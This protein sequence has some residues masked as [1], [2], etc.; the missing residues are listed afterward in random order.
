MVLLSSLVSIRSK[1]Q[2]SISELLYIK[3]KSAA[4]CDKITMGMIAGIGTHKL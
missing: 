2:E 4:P 1:M 3:A